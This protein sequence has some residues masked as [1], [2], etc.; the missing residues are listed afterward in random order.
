MQEITMKYEIIDEI[1]NSTGYVV[2]YKDNAIGYLKWLAKTIIEMYE[3]KTD[4]IDSLAEIVKDLIEMVDTIDRND[5]TKVKIEECPMSVS[6]INV[7]E[8]K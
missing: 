5:Y 2:L 4:D 3:P 6:N 7:M 1:M 8:E